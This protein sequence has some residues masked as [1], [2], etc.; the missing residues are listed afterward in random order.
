MAAILSVRTAI[1]SAGVVSTAVILRLTGPS[2]VDF[3]SAAVPRIYGSLLSWLTP[4]YLYFVINGIIISIAA[5]SRF[6][7]AGAARTE[8]HPT[9][10]ASQHEFVQPEKFT[11]VKA[12]EVEELRMVEASP[13]YGKAEL[14]V[15]GEEVEK[16]AEEDE[17]DFVI[18]RS[19]WTPKR[20]VSRE[21]P[22]EYSAAGE[23]P[24]VSS[25]FSHHRK[26]VKASPEGKALGVARS[27]RNETLEST[28]KTITDG[29]PVP[30]A[31]HLKKSDTWDV[32]GPARENDALALTA[33]APPP[34]RK[35]ETF[36]ERRQQA[37]AGKLRREPSVGQDDLNRRVE[38]FIK[39]FND[40]MRLQRQESFQHYMDMINRGSH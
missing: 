26:T 29:R 11:E 39:K 14:M 30:L 15:Y 12:V 1:A 35:A 37:S 16:K 25:R 8:T 38:A 6:H 20:R 28:W 21:I 18:S 5:S 23:K 34:M 22:T 4:P 10:Q 40:E 7:M 19:S 31:R 33:A 3:L 27:K 2:I 24:L 17:S 36:N 32:H 9:P 13:E